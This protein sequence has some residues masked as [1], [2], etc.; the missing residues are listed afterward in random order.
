M[1]VE[2]S[3]LPRSDHVENEGEGPEQ[4]CMMFRSTSAGE[5]CG[6]NYARVRP[7]PAV[8]DRTRLK[9]YA[10]GQLNY[11]RPAGYT[12]SGTAGPGS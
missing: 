1:G 2:L 12:L 5:F 8:F 10:S 6:D 4:P 3:S 9:S 7:A 11:V